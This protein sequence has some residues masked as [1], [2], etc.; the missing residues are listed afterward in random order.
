MGSSSTHP[1]MGWEG[2]YAGLPLLCVLYDI[3]VR[4]LTIFRHIR[5]LPKSYP[6]ILCLDCYLMVIH[7]IVS[8]NILSRLLYIWFSLASIS[9]SIANKGG[10]KPFD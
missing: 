9:Q 1:D 6:L 2:T 5:M 3:G 4:W 7:V 10:D 8:L